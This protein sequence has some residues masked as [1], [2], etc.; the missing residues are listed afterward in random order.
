M[1]RRIAGLGLLSMV[2]MEGGYAVDDLRIDTVNFIKAL[3][4]GLVGI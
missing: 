4:Q 1:W 3:A 2:V